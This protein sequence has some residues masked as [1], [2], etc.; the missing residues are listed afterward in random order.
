LFSVLEDGTQKVKAHCSIMHAK[1]VG[2]NESRTFHRTSKAFDARSYETNN[3]FFF[4]ETLVAVGVRIR[5][6]RK[7]E[8]D[9]WDGS[10]GTKKT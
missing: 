7:K 9:S 8:Q 1:V 10:V 6:C 2:P 5:L 4:F 3:F